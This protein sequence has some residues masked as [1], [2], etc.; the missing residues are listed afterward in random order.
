MSGGSEFHAAGPA[1]KKVHSPNVVRS[2]GSRSQAN[3]CCCAA[4]R[5]DDVYEICWASARVYSVHDRAQ[6]KVDTTA[7]RQPVQHHAIPVLHH[8]PFLFRFYIVCDI[9]NALVMFSNCKR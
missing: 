2:C 3:T 5:M 1:C 8:R 4:G 9:C 6:F 7:D